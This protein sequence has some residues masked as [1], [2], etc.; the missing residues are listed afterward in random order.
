M[1]CV[2]PVVRTPGTCERVVVP[3]GEREGTQ[4]YQLRLETAPVLLR[5]FLTADIEP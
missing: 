5:R 1:L 3:E 4:G 2:I